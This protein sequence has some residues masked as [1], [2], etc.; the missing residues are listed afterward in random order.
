MIYGIGTD[1]VSIERIEKMCKNH[2]VSVVANKLLSRIEQ[3]EWP[4]ANNPVMFLAKRFAAKEAFA[5]A[6]HT[7]L[8]S[9]VT[10]RNIGIG[11]DELGRPEFLVEPSLQAWLDERRI[12]KIHLSLSDEAGKIVAFAVAEYME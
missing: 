6:V 3:L 10:L 11:H 12:G 2:G 5:K 7:G 9:P 4:S 8:R 1:M